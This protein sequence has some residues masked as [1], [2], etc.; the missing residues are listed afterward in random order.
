MCPSLR[1]ALQEGTVTHWP[2]TLSPKGEGWG[3]DQF[4]VFIIKG[5]NLSII[6]LLTHL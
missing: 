6:L 3:H 4:L 2:H 1:I 5:E